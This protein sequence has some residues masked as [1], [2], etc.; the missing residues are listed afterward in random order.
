MADI[1]RLAG[2]PRFMAE[3]KTEAYPSLFICES[4]ENWWRL[5]PPLVVDDKQP[6]KGISKTKV[7]ADH[8][9]DATMYLL[10]SRPY[11]IGPEERQQQDFD[12]YREQY[13]QA[14]ED[15]GA[16]VMDPYAT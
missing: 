2:N 1:S 8:L 5:C 15:A 14:R 12:S 4:C 9:A 3:G 6:D 16:V 11:S 7:Q 10:M 13:L